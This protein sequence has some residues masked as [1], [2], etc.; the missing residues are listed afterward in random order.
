MT[1][2]FENA[3]KKVNNALD[4]VWGSADGMRSNDL[5]D[6]LQGVI[7]RS[8]GMIADLQCDTPPHV[9]LKG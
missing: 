6:V 1:I 4:E 5:R 7:D 2:E 3:V 8:Q 9:T